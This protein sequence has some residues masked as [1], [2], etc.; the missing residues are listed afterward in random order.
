MPNE[1]NKRIDDL[2]KEIEFLKSLILFD[3]LTGLHTRQGFKEEVLPFFHQAATA[4]TAGTQRRSL[5]LETLSILFIDIDDF[6]QVNDTKGHEEGDR[7]LKKVANIIQDVMRGTDFIA[8]WGGEEIVATVL[9]APEKEAAEKVAEK[10]RATIE[11]ETDVTVSIGVAELAGEDDTLN[12]LVG[13]TD[14]AMYRAKEE[15][16]NKVVRYSE[17]D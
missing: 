9:G 10:V 3:P 7:I 11:D 2:E 1:T 16:K 12:K 13:R 4:K 5:H 14:K 8:R 6:K 17:L 15:G